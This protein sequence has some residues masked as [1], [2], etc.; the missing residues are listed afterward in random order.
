MSRSLHPEVPQVIDDAGR[1]R[2][3]QGR[4]PGVRVAH[5]SQCFGNI[6]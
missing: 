2:F 4:N 5:R 6:S 3:C 1:D